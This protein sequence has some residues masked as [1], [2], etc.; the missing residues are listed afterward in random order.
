MQF[1]ELKDILDARVEEMPESVR[2]HVEA[3]KYRVLADVITFSVSNP[4]TEQNTP[5]PLPVKRDGRGGKVHTPK[6]PFTCLI[7]GETTIGQGRQKYC[8]KKECRKARH[9]MLND[10]WKERKKDES[11]SDSVFTQVI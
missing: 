8:H 5:A 4:I 3:Y 11:I 2:P 1:K 9:K 7:C 10:A 6:T